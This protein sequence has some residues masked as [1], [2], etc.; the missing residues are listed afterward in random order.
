MVDERGDWFNLATRLSRD[1]MECATGGF[2]ALRSHVKAVKKSSPHRTVSSGY[3]DEV[4]T[5]LYPKV[6]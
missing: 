1:G 2:R 5:L 4:Q 3:M 6:Q